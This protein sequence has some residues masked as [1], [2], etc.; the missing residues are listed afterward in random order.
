MFVRVWYYRDNL[1]SGL[2]LLIKTLVLAGALV[3]LLIPTVVRADSFLDLTLLTSV[4]M[5]QYMVVSAHE[6]PVE[7]ISIS[8]NLESAPSQIQFKSGILPPIFARIAQ[9]ESSNKQFNKHG[10]PLIGITGDIGRFQI[11]PIHLPEAKRLGINVYTADGN[12][13]FATILYLRNGLRDWFSSRYCW[14]K[15]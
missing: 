11:N 13:A 9:C 10:G 12:E 14:L 6:V 8:K 3:L 2:Q 1:Y 7:D 5:A 15:R 4:F